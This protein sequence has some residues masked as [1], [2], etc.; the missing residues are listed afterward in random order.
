MY[1]M[2]VTVILTVVI[3]DSDQSVTSNIGKTW[4]CFSENVTNLGSVP[5]FNGQRIVKV[6]QSARRC[7]VFTN[8]FHKKFFEYGRT[9][10]FIFY[11][12][13]KKIF[14]SVNSLDIK[15]F[16]EFGMGL[17][18]KSELYFYFENTFWLTQMPG[19]RRFIKNN[20]FFVKSFLD[21]NNNANQIPKGANGMI[22]NTRSDK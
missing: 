19:F 10:K 11:S 12:V 5:K 3:T 2:I 9:D 20:Q 1:C 4:W 16:A 7:N 18:N 14:H 17:C 6:F 13:C 21:F 22:H 8:I 15:V